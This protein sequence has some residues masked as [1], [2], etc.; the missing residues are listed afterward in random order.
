[1]KKFIDS[2]KNKIIN[3]I[4]N[5]DSNTIKLIINEINRCV[6]DE[7]TI[8]V[9]GNGGSA[10]TA[11][12]IQNDLGVGLKTKDI[13]NLNIISLCDNIPVLTALANDTGY[14]NIFFS[15]LSGKIKK[16]D[17]IIAIS[18][19][20]N[21]SSIIKAVDYSQSQ[22]AIVIGMTGFDGGLLKHKSDISYH[23]D[24]KYGDYGVVE[25][26]HLMLD[27]M[28]YTYYIET[29]GVIDE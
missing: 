15:Q 7:S 18:C 24:T 1:M 17:V 13:L 4:K 3:I 21:S 8:Y 26:L 11:S 27:H 28:I 25:D 5:L 10:S 2:Y 20:G 23:I 6:M 22:G 12:H 14:E 16:N 29:G 9:I 19:S